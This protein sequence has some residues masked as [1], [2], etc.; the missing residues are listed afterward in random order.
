MCRITTER[1]RA[2]VRR[3]VSDDRLA[4]I[5]GRL[6]SISFDTYCVEMLNFFSNLNFVSK[7]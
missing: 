5:A 3:A 1:H 7:I 6:V 4:A 2:E